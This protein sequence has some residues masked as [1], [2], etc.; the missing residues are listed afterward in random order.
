MKRVGY[1][2]EVDATTGKARVNFASE[3][4][5]SDWLFI[6]FPK[7]K[8]DK[9]QYTP[10]VGEHVFCILEDDGATG[11]ILGAFYSDRDTPAATLQDAQTEGMVFADGTEV[12]YDQGAGEYVINSVG[13]IKAI[14]GAYE[15]EVS[16]A[17]IAVR[18]AT[19]S[20]KTDL[21]SILD[22]LTILTVP[23]PVGP[24]SVPVNAASFVAAKA[25]IATY[26]KT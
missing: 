4:I 1:I 25:S 3:G 14:V 13:K 17:G 24:S 16:T 8:A 18:G 19:G 5:V 11:F 21:D 6:L 7:T 22:A 15:I 12:Y 10:A 23:T 20:L 9:Y 2:T 26:L